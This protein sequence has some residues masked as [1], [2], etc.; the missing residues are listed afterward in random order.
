[1]LKASLSHIDDIYS[2]R[3]GLERV[4]EIVALLPP[5][6]SPVNEVVTS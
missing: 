3:R 1:M 4:R 6:D 2:S 5:A